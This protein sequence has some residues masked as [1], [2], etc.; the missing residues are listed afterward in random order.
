M[1]ERISDW[2]YGH[3]DPQTGANLLH[4]A[5]DVLGLTLFVLSL[6]WVFA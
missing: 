2:L 5:L 6:W 1:K 3:V 4:F